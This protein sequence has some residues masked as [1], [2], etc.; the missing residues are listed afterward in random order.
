[1]S[2]N[3]LGDPDPDA[4]AGADD[5][6]IRLLQVPDHWSEQQVWDLHERLGLDFLVS[7]K[8]YASRVPGLA[9]CAVLKYRSNSAA[10]MALS[11]LSGQTVTLR[12]GESTQLETQLGAPSMDEWVERSQLQA[13]DAGGDTGGYLAAAAVTSPVPAPP[14]APAPAPKEAERKAEESQDAGPALLTPNSDP[15][16][17]YVKD[18]PGDFR[19]SDVDRLHDELDLARP[20]STKLLKNRISH[21]TL[22][23]ILRY[24][25]EKL[26]AAALDVLHDRLELVNMRSGKKCQPKALYATKKSSRTHEKLEDDAEQERKSDGEE[27][28]EDEELSHLP[29]VFLS[30]L[31]SNITENGIRHI[32]EEVGAEVR[33]LVAIK[34]LVN[35]PKFQTKNATCLV[36]Y[37]DIGLASS[38][39]RKVNGFVV[40]HPDDKSRPIRAKVAKPPKQPSVPA[41]TDVYVGEV[42]LNWDEDEVYNLLE[43]VGLDKETCVSVKFLAQ[44]QAKEFVGVI[45]RMST[46]E[47]ALDAIDALPLQRV[48]YAGKSRQLKARLADAPKKG[49]GKGK[50][51]DTWRSRA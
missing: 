3:W 35:P 23:A 36:R 21:D 25:T 38:C 8:L 15:L 37:R 9:R 42:P 45:L 27:G 44:R 31:P 17:L 48:S 51:A 6:T 28:E 41:T 34:I 18:L 29:S 24:E 47:A 22:C 32:L 11:S 30:E 13:P 19:K 7:V 14:P 1:M 33:E 43:E 50:N 16:T 46:R 2:S 39:A 40:Y 26:A 49:S 20:V 12:N 10:W 5:G 4:S